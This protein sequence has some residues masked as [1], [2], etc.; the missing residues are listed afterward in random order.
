MRE[1]WFD[2]GL[3]E[4]WLTVL[5]ASPEVIDIREQQRVDFVMDGQKRWH[6][7]DYM[8]TWRSG[9][10]S[11]LP[12]K[13]QKDIKPDLHAVLQAISDQHGDNIADDFRILTELDIDVVTIANSRQILSCA[14][15]FDYEAQDFILEELPRLGEQVSLR[16]LD[17]LVGEGPR[18]SR[19]AMALIPSGHLAIDPGQPLSADALLWNRFTTSEMEGGAPA[20]H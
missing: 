6:Y 11:A 10:R 19:A 13:Y 5:M 15:D 17:A 16:D 1:I 7:F 8:V 2:S 4:K 3:E 9:W 12:V 20:L 14:R 18:G